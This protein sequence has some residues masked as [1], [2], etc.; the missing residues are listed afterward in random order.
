MA[1]EAKPLHEIQQ[2]LKRRLAREISIHEIAAEIHKVLKEIPK[3]Q[4]RE[5][6]AWILA[7]RLNRKWSSMNPPDLWRLIDRRPD[8]L[9]GVVEQYDWDLFHEDAKEIHEFAKEIAR[10]EKR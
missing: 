10:E 8:E 6:V 1:D 7:Q 9:A 2:E 4:T 3:G 5:K